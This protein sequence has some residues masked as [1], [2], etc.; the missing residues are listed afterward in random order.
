VQG[1]NDDVEGHTYTDVQYA[2]NGEMEKRRSIITE[3]RK[4]NT[5]V[6]VR[7]IDGEARDGDD[8]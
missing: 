2:I 7:Q 1:H 5:Y 6:T 8:V 3:E 4:S